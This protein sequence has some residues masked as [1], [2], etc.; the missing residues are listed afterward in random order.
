V[1]PGWQGINVPVP[2]SIIDAL[3]AAHA[4]GARLLS[5]CSGSFVLAAAGLLDGKRATT[6]WRYADELHRRYPRIHVDPDV[7]RFRAARGMSPG[8]IAT[9]NTLD[10]S[11]MENRM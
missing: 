11:L 3:R 9:Q 10:S 6:R 2:A 4:N 8:G 5:I 7:R 1:V